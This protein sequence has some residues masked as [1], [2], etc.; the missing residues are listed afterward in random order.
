MLKNKQLGV[1]IKYYKLIWGPFQNKQKLIKYLNKKRKKNSKQIG[2]DE[3]QNTKH[4]GL[5][6]IIDY[7]KLNPKLTSMC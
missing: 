5:G 3:E 2:V 4:Q 6:F 7:S 1:K